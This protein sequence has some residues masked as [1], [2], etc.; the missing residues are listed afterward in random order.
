M[1]GLDQIARL[2]AE[3]ARKE[4]N[5]LDGGAGAFGAGRP[6]PALA[7]P[8]KEKVGSNPRKGRREG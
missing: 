3:E 4:Q 8:A 5:R 1:I 7:T 6:K 2:A